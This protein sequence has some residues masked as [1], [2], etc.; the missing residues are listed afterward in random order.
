MNTILYKSSKGIALKR[1]LLLA[2]IFNVQCTM[3]NVFAQINIQ[4]KVFGG[5]RQANVNGHTF[6]KIGADKHDVII[7]AVYGGNDIAGTIGSSSKP[8]GLVL[9]GSQ[10]HNVA[11]IATYN[12]F[13]RTEKEASGK[14]LFIGQLFGGGYGDYN[15]TKTGDDYSTTITYKVATQVAVPNT[16][17]VEYRWEYVDQ[18]VT[19]DNII[20][21]EIDRAYVD[22]HGGTLGYVY[23]GGDNVTVTDKVQICINNSSDADSNTEGVQPTTS[24]KDVQDNT[25]ELLTTAR[26][27]AMGINT[28]YY[29]PDFLISRVFG[30]NNKA[31]MAIMPTWHLQQGSIENLYSGGNEGRMTSSIGLLLEIRPEVKA[32]EDADIVNRK[33]VI[34]NVYGGC[35]K[36]DVHPLSGSNEVGSQEIQLPSDMVNWQGQPYAFPAGLAARV[37]VYGGNINNV[38]GGNDVA[39]KVTGGNAVGVY[40]SIRGSIYG[41]GNGSYPYTDN[42]ELLKSP[43]YSD[44]YYGDKIT[45]STTS[46]QAL[47][48]YRPNAEQVSIRV[49]GEATKPTIIGNAIFLGGNSAT[50]KNTTTTTPMVELKVGSHVIADKVFLGNNG[51]YM[52]QCTNDHDV[53]KLYSKYVKVDDDGSVD[54][55]NTE[56]TGYSKFISVN[57]TNADNF[58]QYMDGCALDLMPSVVFDSSYED[59]STYFGSFFC[60]GNVGSMTKSGLTTINFNKPLIVYNKVVGGCNDAYITATP[61]NAAYQG[62][63]IGSETERPLSLGSE[64]RYTDTSG[65]INDRLVL[66]FNGLK[67]MPL[68]SPIAETDEVTDEGT[69]VTTSAPYITPH[70][71][72]VWNTIKLGVRDD[73]GKPVP[74]AWNDNSWS[75]AT[76]GHTAA[77]NS[78]INRR[79]NDGNIYGGCC[80]SGVV[81]GNVVININAT[82]VDRTGTHG[83]FDVVETDDDTG[84]DKLY[85]NDYTITQAVSGVIL[86]QQ[87]MDVLGSALNIF[88]GGKGIDTE[89]WGSTT[90]NLTKGYVFQIFGGSEQGAIGKRKTTTTDGVTI[91]DTDTYGRYVYEYNPKYSTYVNLSGSASKPG[92]PKS[93]DMT[94]DMAEAEFLYGGGFEGPIAG[95]THIN[96]GNGRIFNSFAGSC[97]AD[98]QGH[99]ETYIGRQVNSDGTYTDGFPYVRDHVY[100]G[101]DLGGKIL[102][103]SNNAESI[104][105]C[106]FQSRLRCYDDDEGNTDTSGNNSAYLAKVYNTDMLNASAYIEYIQGHVYN[107]FGGCYGVYDYTSP[108]YGKYF[109]ATGG[110]GTTATGNNPNI[111]Q[112]RDGYSKPY[113]KNAFVNFRPMENSNNYNTVN[114]IYGAGQGY[115]GEKE[116]NLMQESSY[117][118]IDIPQTMQAF[119]STEIFG[120]GESGGVGMR[121]A[122]ATAAATATAH[123]ASAIIDLLSGHIKAAY[124]GSF[125]EGITRRSIVNVPSG[126]TIRANS[127]F[128]G[129]YG[130]VDVVTRVKKDENN[131]TV[132]DDDGNP[133]IEIVSR[134]PRIDVACDVYEAI[135]NY[136]SAD[137]TIDNALYGG[138]NAC[139]RTLYGQVNVW[140]PVYSNK[141]K[142][143]T[144]TVY[145][146]GCGVD[147]WSQYTEVNLYNGA[148]VYEAYGG[149]EDGKV[150]NLGSVDK[151]KDTQTNLFTTLEEGYTDLGLADGT[152]ANSNRLF[153]VDA[154]RPKYYN[155]N[156][157][158]NKGATVW[159]YCYGGGL[160]HGNIAY[161]GN[162]YGTTY[163]DL[164]GGI[165]KKDLYAAGTTGAVKDSLG[166]KG[167]FIA[168]ATA[169]I[170]GGTARN[171]YGGGWKGSVGQHNGVERTKD[172]KQ[173]IDYLDAPYYNTTTHEL[174]D[175]PGETHVI[176]GKLKE[177][178]PATIPVGETADYYFYNGIPAVERNAYGGGEGGAVWGTTNLTMNNGYIGYRYHTTAETGWADNAATANIDERYEEK[179]EDETYKDEDGHFQ[180]NKRLN[181][182]GCIFGGGYV[183]N[184][185]VDFANVNMYGGHV[186]NAL[187][188]GGEIA[189]VGRGKIQETTGTDGKPVRTLQGIY[190]PGKTQIELYDGYVHRNVFGGG[191]GYNNLGDVG[192][193]FSDGYVFGQTEVHIH[194]GEI[195]TLAELNK[196]NGNVFGG[197]D[198]GYVYSAYEYTDDLGNKLPRKGVKSGVRY[199]GDGRYQGYYYEHEWENNTDDEQYFIHYNG[200]ERKLTEDCKVLIEPYCKLTGANS[201]TYTIKYYQGQMVSEN[202]LRYLKNNASTYSSQLDALD[203]F[204]KVTATDGISFTRTFNKGDYVVASA[205]NT[206][207][208]KTDSE[209]GVLEANTNDDGII[210]HNAVFAGGNT[211]KGADDAHAYANSTSV[212]GNATAS[213]HDCYHRDLITIGTGHIGGLYG[214]GNLTLVDGYRGLNITNYGTDYHYLYEEENMKELTLS[215]YEALLDREKDYYELRYKCVQDCMDDDKTSYY[216]YDAV[217]HPVP[218]TL[219][220]DDI[221]TLFANQNGTNGTVNMFSTDSNGNPI[222]NPTYWQQ[223]GVC[224]IYAGR[225]LNTIQRA[226][227]CGV[228]G[229]R[230]VMQGAQDRVPEVVDY[231]KYTINRVR[232]VSLNRKYS[233]INADLTDTQHPKR[234]MHG[235]YFGIYSVVHFLGAL[236]SDFDFGSET[237]GEGE[238]RTTDN[239]DDKYSAAISINNNNIPYGNAAYTFYNWKKANHTEQLRNNG[240]SHNKVALASGVYLE[241][242][243]EEST[244]KELNEKVWGLITGVVELDLINVQQGM[245]GGFVYA[246]NVHGIRTKTNLTN[247]TLTALNAGAATRWDYSYEEPSLTSNAADPNQ[248]E[249]QTSG[250]FVHSTQTIIDDCY[251]YSG[252]YLG[253]DRVPA[254][255]W[256]IK[257]SVYVYDQYIS[258]YTGASNAY[259]ETVNLPLTITAASHGKMKLLDVQPN[260]Y[261]YYSNSNKDKLRTEQKLVINNKDYYLNDPISYW[262]WYMLSKAERDLFVDKTYVTTDSCMIG[263]TYYAPGYVMLPTEYN[264]L[265]TSAEGNPQVVETG[266][267]AVPAVTRVILD[268]NNQPQIVKDKEGNTVYIAFSDVFHESNNLSHDTGYML[269]Y[270][271]NNPKIWNTW[272]TPITGT[273]STGKITTETYEG[274]EINKNDYLYGPTYSFTD[275]DGGVLGQRDYKVSDIIPK[276]IKT[277]YDGITTSG[278]GSAITGEQ[279]LFEVAYIALADIDIVRSGNTAHLKKGSTLSA[280]EANGASNVAQALVCTKTIQISTDDII[281]INSKMTATDKTNYISKV[282]AKITAIAGSAISEMSDLTSEQ[283]NAL[284]AVKKKELADLLQ[285]K[286]DIDKYIEDAYYCTK[287]GLYGGDYYDGTKNYAGLEAWSSMTKADQQK[288]AYNYDAL[289]LLIDPSYR[290]GE[291]VKYQYDSSAANVAGAEANLAHYSIVQPIDYT[292]TFTGTTY[293]Y[294]GVSLVN[295]ETYN[296]TVYES[297]P[298]EK[299]HYAPITVTTSD[300]GNNP[301][302]FYVVNSPLLV[303]YTPYA[304]GSLITKDEYDILVA[305]DALLEEGEPREQDKITQLTFNT[306]GTWYFCREQYTPIA[307]GSD[308]TVGTLINSTQYKAL[309]NMQEGFIIHGITPKETSTLFVSRFSDIDDLSTEKII[310]VIYEYN[311]EESDVLGL[312]ITPVTERHVVNIHI[313]FKTGA[314]IVEDIDV[315]QIILPGD[316]LGLLEP[317]VIEGVSPVVGGGWELYETEYDADIHNGMEYIPDTDPLYW[318]QNGYWLRYYA[319]SFV[320][321]KTY[322][323]KVQVSVANYHDLT[324]VMN[325]KEHH[326]YVD[327]P[328]LIRLREPKIYIND[329][330]DGMNQLKSLFDLSLLTTTPTGTLAGHANLKP[331]VNSCQNLEF[332]MRTNVNQTGSWTPIANNSGECFEGTFHG[333][334]YY[335]SGL[336]HSLFNHLCGDVYNLGVTGSFTGAGIAET[337]S[338]YVENCWIK[339]SGTPTKKTD[340]DTHSHFAVFGEPTRRQYVAVA[341]GTT[342]TVGKTYYTS[343]TG[344]GEF[345]VGE[346]DNYV[347]GENQYYQKLYNSVVQVVNSYYPESDDYDVPTSTELDHGKPV[348]MPDKDFYNGTVAYDLNGFYLYKR[349]CD[350]EVSSSS[351]TYSYLTDV[352]NSTKTIHTDGKYGTDNQTYCSSGYGD[353]K[354][355]EDR[356]ADGDF[357]Y[358]AGEI[359]DYVDDR[360]CYEDGK[361]RFYPIWPDDYLFFGQMLTYDWN[362]SRP[363]QDVP[364]SIVKDGGRLADTDLSNRVYRAPAY[365]RNATM[366]VAHFNPNVNLIAQSKPKNAADNTMKDAYPGMTAI[367]F[368]GHNDLSKGYQLGLMGVE[369]DGTFVDPNASTAVSTRFY[370]PL[371][372]DDGLQ[373]IVNRDETPNLLVYAPAR[374]ASEG[375]ANQ[376]TYDV[377]TGYFKEPAYSDYDESSSYYTDSKEYNRVFAAPTQSVFGHLV[378]NNLTTTNDHLLVDKKDFNCPISYNMNSYRMWYQRVP[379]IYVEPVWNGNT[380][381]TKGWEGVSL[382]FTAEFVTT[383]RK[384]EITHFYSGSESSKNGTGTKIGHEYWLREYRDITALTGSAA[385]KAEA[386]FT[387]PNASDSWEDKMKP[388]E[389]KNSFLWDYYYN[390]LNAL[391]GNEHL[392]ANLDTYQTYYKPDDDGVVNTFNNYTLLTKAVPYIIGFPG[393]KFYEFDLSGSFMATTTAEDNPDKVAEQTISFVSA[394]GYQVGVSDTELAAMTTHVTQNGYTF[395]PNYLNEKL[396][397]QGKLDDGTAN[398]ITVYTLNAEGSSYDLPSSTNT[399]TPVA[400]RPYFTSAAAA[401]QSSGNGDGS[402]PVTRSILFTQSDDSQLSQWAQESHDDMDGPGTLSISAGRHKILVTS[403]LKAKAT[404]VILNAAGIALHTFDIEPGETVETRIINSGV[405]I[406]RTEDGHHLKKVA[407][408]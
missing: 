115:F 321:G 217:N 387:Y 28:E 356:Y 122:P 347:A 402:R 281:Y 121:V 149:G 102:G 355:V 179:I 117:I 59:Y 108:L 30:G 80:N 353:N 204:G 180:D 171:V 125:K 66:N 369:T 398:G 407:V 185:S 276:N 316:L 18:D 368:A 304:V 235:N 386:L 303:G 212:Y 199:D 272:Y 15:Y 264:T 405:Y 342:L 100:G 10:A 399:T 166:V 330:T 194:G 50:L 141:A 71:P 195:G 378:Q 57:M 176:I 324:D 19:L 162:V 221:F 295:G 1:L 105:D 72:L 136:K 317:N 87:G 229:S 36:A 31:E 250:N 49:L 104:A 345:T 373:S 251:N 154:T 374:T 76:T 29:N 332:F 133:V 8:Q 69:G 135:V 219:T 32:N 389:M 253:P 2:V 159:G 70:V 165:V 292:A 164:L 285:V 312:H 174:I 344:A 124:G 81:N 82:V 91:A 280:T 343:D 214:D 390:N 114:Q 192:K 329:A 396:T 350:N 95:N 77:Y 243:T 227:F 216:A 296:R 349:Y 306:S 97:N 252:K 94:E 231:T 367:D 270:T 288:F 245:G 168:S 323:N 334:G 338:G 163:I 21:P 364:S 283:L 6:V 331:Q 89:I 278:H 394:T 137:A 328:D 110:E 147:T 186:R 96:L 265:K 293:T 225:I 340:E 260:K 284:T 41:G 234:K 175:I 247:T 333:D 24:I 86:G 146:A 92:V 142:G 90:V 309:I 357:R 42:A 290:F 51:E 22:I 119:Q 254:H 336:D 361:P 274:G 34:D 339:T 128:G 237:S 262:D 188:G 352:T 308:V 153:T 392:D 327:I 16:D 3:F 106:N 167:D 38:Y 178:L 370:P 223:N 190:R 388:K 376:A 55:K 230:L 401:R 158:I 67:I 93:V 157:H 63:I 7:N 206:L 348:Q 383:V 213:I 39:G 310:T 287:A 182:A 173:Y 360:L 366:S 44:F 145:G 266:G 54:F 156:V 301:T 380:R 152:P 189:A 242:T 88:G 48:D 211:T 248:K 294:N 134:T 320:G 33:L 60:G 297:L 111:G 112:A 218:S 61:Y 238:I 126:S 109:Y 139:R 307:G 99:T 269:T 246:K 282:N 107:I 62:G 236:T 130:L 377:L 140:T 261:A 385:E 25:K 73:Q 37:L 12:T 277:K 322:S 202:N 335:V 27:L 13:V 375:Y 123:Q 406:V 249:W 151:W 45:G 172:G 143:Y 129:A 17:P 75:A 183:D 83:V 244:G 170:E 384:G 98:I 58:A 205:L 305:K 40:H 240:N 177:N 302:T 144:A 273:S 403:A 14:H 313:D 226:D 298:N 397:N 5:A 408:K 400:F 65:N 64:P 103:Q 47:N 259:T 263:T 120:A 187:F 346:E 85:G 228:F 255:Y 363:H 23:G 4:G 239:S 127:L 26:K 118:L 35:R 215:Q 289:D 222:P 208:N 395:K 220:A 198:I 224:S 379:D 68:R 268:E 286:K 318:Y 362:E 148:E 131:Q 311:Y 20:K 325:D 267:S 371:L 161:S 193:L 233:V 113:M 78:T 341:S 74:V 210:I 56:D 354:Y 300:V 314:P 52:K 43:I 337:G 351:K 201:K 279:A 46:L 84:E 326:Y 209:W 9:D 184:S 372:D 256:Y 207:G 391:S 271:V 138:N 299:R 241:L 116:E 150:L 200:T 197:G 196:G 358:A 257:G 258:A 393:S 319:L 155:T 79:F 160:G 291:G 359:P 382:P 132:T 381:T 191:R 101:N 404:V 11:D 315:P 232:E 53:L 181:D 203:D 275:S 365:F 169:Y